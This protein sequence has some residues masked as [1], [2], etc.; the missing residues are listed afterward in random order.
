[1]DTYLSLQNSASWRPKKTRDIIQSEHP[2]NQLCRSQSKG[3][4]EERYTSSE[5]GQVGCAGAVNSAFLCPLF[6]SAPQQIPPVPTHTGKGIYFTGS[7]GSNANKLLQK[8][9]CTLPPPPPE[10]M[11]P[12]GNLGSLKLTHEINHHSLVTRFLSLS[13]RDDQI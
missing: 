13:Y 9:S 1:M 10:I 5:E 7:T 3:R 11:F 12:L 2:R 4:G 6:K 8:H